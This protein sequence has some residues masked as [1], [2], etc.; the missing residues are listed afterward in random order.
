MKGVEYDSEKKLIIFKCQHSEGRQKCENEKAIEINFK[1][2]K[3]GPQE[4]QARYIISRKG[5]RAWGGDILCPEHNK[6]A[7]YD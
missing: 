5:W 6:E 7:A 4:A 3:L 2:G 1:K